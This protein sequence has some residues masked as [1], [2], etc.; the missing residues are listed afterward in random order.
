V[1]ATTTD[2]KDTF[3][4]VPG[5]RH[6]EVART[7]AE[8][9]P[10]ALSLLD[11]FG[12]W[13]NLGVSL[14]GFTGAIF[15]LQPG[16]PGTPELSLAAALTAIV[17]GTVLGT[18]ALALAG[19]PG[20]RTGAPAMVLLRGLFGARLSYL[21][22]A[23]NILQCLAWAVFELVTIATAAH[24]VAPALPKWG[25]V[26]IA[27]LAT[28]LLT[29]RP[30]GAIR[31][32]RRYAAGAVLVVMCYL[33]VQL[34]RHPLPELT[35]GTW[36]GY[37]AATDTVVA[38][39]ISFAP[40]A[41]DY[42][43]HSRSPRAAFAGTMA[44]YS[45]TQVLCYVIGLLALVTV[46]HGHSQDIYGAFIALPAGALCFAILATRELDQSFADVYS[47]AVSMQNMRPLWDRRILA[48]TIAALATAG[49]L[50]L[51]IADYENFLVLIGSLFVPLSA[52]LITD[53]FVTSRGR[54]DLSAAARA[55][56][57]M[58]LPWAAGFVTYQL[59]NPGYVSWWAAA[60]TSFGHDLGFTPAS[61]MSASIL[62]FAVAAAITLPAGWLAGRRAPAT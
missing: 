43:R 52:V 59:I 27:G 38:V 6:S 21:P 12:L 16:G 51:N 48:G 2:Q 5:D 24:T 35:H 7:L 9:V 1:A 40:L 37:W 11:Q 42:T 57:P 17:A 44:G 50:W 26:L 13:G 34:I 8:P 39:A 46:A 47:T 30:L 61:W 29:I 45:A 41:A 25:Y 10:Q 56:W 58:L 62:S 31:V 4:T 60:W 23:L 22:T 20:A 19:L 36:S 49:A 54:W 15:V 3:V 28:A 18:A 53:Y 14:L 33:F 32:L 55:R